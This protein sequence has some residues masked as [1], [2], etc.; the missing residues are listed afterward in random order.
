MKLVE[1]RVLLLGSL[2]TLRVLEY[3]GCIADQQSSS[4][5]HSFVKAANL[6]CA[7][8]TLHNGLRFRWP[9]GMLQSPGCAIPKQFRNSTTMD[10]DIRVR[11]HP[12]A[13]KSS[14]SIFLEGYIRV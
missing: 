5:A 2:R 3:A 11:L 13:I 12:A 7:Q 6:G 9:E 8:V 10:V 1:T 14:D 4:L